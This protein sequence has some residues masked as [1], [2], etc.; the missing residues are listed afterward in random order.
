MSGGTIMRHDCG[1]LL[2]QGQRCEC[3]PIP[4]RDCDCTFD[5][6][7][8]IIGPFCNSEIRRVWAECLIRQEVENGTTMSDRSIASEWVWED[9]GC[10]TH[11]RHRIYCGPHFIAALHDEGDGDE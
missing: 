2:I 9:C 11:D 3:D 10:G 7:R 4:E 1:R 8:Q 5:G 6:N